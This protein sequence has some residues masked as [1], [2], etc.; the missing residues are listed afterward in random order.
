MYIISFESQPTMKVNI[1]N[2]CLDFDLKVR[3]WFSAGAD[4]NRHSALEVYAGDMKNV[5]LIPFLSTFG[6]VLTYELESKSNKPS[7]QFKL[8]H[9]RLFLV[10]KSEGYKKFRVFLHMI[11]YDE[12]I[13]WNET[14]LEE[15]YHHYVNQLST[16]TDP[17]KDIWWIRGGIVLM[18]NLELDFTQRDGVLNITISEGVKD[19]NAKIPERFYRKL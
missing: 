2:Q 9:I 5:N 19:G 6:G 8:T 11:E 7:N 15:Y 3:R 10:W 18:T 16:Y 17:I 13:E 4:K 14:E 12:L 1:H